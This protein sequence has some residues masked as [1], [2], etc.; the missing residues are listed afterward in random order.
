MIPTK[1]G[2]RLVPTPDGFG[3]VTLGCHETP[4]P[5]HRALMTAETARL[6][7]EAKAGLHPWQERGAHWAP[8][9]GATAWLAEEN[10][11]E[12]EILRGGSR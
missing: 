8:L 5:A 9:T 6:N 3:G 2:Y 10:A 11:Q 7:F 4:R 12:H 1:Y